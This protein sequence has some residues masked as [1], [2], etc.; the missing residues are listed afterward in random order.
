[1]I[2]QKTCVH[3]CVPV[4]ALGLSKMHP[5]NTSTHVVKHQLILKTSS[6]FTVVTRILIGFIKK[7]L[8]LNLLFSKTLRHSGYH[9]QSSVTPSSSLDSPWMCVCVCVWGG[10]GGG[11]DRINSKS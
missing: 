4:Y 9:P 6:S 5:H 3:L 8:Q 1:M 7:E 2:S 10:G 11:I